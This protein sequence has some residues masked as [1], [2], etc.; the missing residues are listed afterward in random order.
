[1]PGRLP[2][3]THFYTKPIVG[4]TVHMPV[5]LFVARP[6]NNAS[7][8]CCKQYI[9]ANISSRLNNGE[10]YQ[11]L[12]ACQNEVLSECLSKDAN[13]ELDQQPLTVAKHL[14]EVL[15]MPLIVLETCYCE[16]KTK[17]VEW[18]LHFYQPP[19]STRHAMA[20]QMLN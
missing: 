19:G 6:Y 1:M 14:A 5:H 2:H 3:I 13:C 11:A 8:A 12:V 4:N 17:Q 18:Q 7:L 10:G 20:R 15:G 9:T 16:I